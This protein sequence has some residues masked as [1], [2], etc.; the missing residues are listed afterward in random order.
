M[1]LLSDEAMSPYLE[2]VTEDFPARLSVFLFGAG[3]SGVSPADAAARLLE[4]RERDTGKLRTGHVKLMLDGSIQ[5]FTARLQEPGYFGDEPNGIWVVSPAEFEAALSAF[6]QAG[7]LVHV[8]CNG[9]QATELFLNTMEKVLVAQP[10]PDHRHTVTHSQMTTP[11]QYKRMA[12]MG[13]CA[14]IF[15]NHIWAWG[16]EH[17]D[18]TVGPDRAARMNATATALRCG[19]P[20]SL[21]CDTPVTPLSPLM[22]VKHA[23]TRLTVSGRV[24]GEHERI[25]AEQALHAVT[26]GG[27]Y[28]LK[29]DHEV[30]SLEPGK[31]A[32]M[33]V[34]D[35][36]PLA[37]EAENIGEIDVLGTVVGGAHH[38]SN[39]HGQR[40]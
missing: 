24:V 39:V 33:A 5:G 26:L 6:H 20:F 21:H 34:L 19:V 14:N 12:A 18:L 30:G 31:F 13:M 38:G 3:K 10:R 32:D 7:L 8:H 37:V 25:S 2:A 15:S 16:D 35:D 23:V 40:S 4:L 11:A 1:A 9:D 28:L 17:I 36:D 29:M 27:A 22:T